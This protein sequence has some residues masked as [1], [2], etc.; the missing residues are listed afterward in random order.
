MTRAFFF[1]CVQLVETS[2]TWTRLL[3]SKLDVTDTLVSPYSIDT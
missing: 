1:C 2:V 3:R